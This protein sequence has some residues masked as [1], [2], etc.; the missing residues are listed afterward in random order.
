M[1][2]ILNQGWYVP[3][4]EGYTLERV[5]ELLRDMGHTP[6]SVKDENGEVKPVEDYEVAA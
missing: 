1:T 5:L 2:V 4:P 6:V 3:I